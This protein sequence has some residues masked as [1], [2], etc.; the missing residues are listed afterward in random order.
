MCDDCTEQDNTKAP[1]EDGDSN[2][3]KDTKEDA[4]LLRWAR[5]G[6]GVCEVVTVE[7]RAL[8]HG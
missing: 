6:P 8:V 4:E 5:A 3:A 7:W 1:A 2:E